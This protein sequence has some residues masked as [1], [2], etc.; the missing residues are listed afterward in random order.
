M[1]CFLAL[2]ALCGTAFPQA[3]QYNSIYRGE[4][5]DV[6][7]RRPNAFLV[8]MTGTRKPGR[9]LDVGMGQGR[10]SIFLAQQGWDVT[11]IDP[12]DEGVRLAK[13]EAARLG[14]KIHAEVITFEQFDFGENRWDLIVLT[15]EPTKAI[16]PKVERA[17]KPGGA[18][19]VEDRHLDTLRVWPGA[20]FADN[21]LVSLFPGLRVLRYEDV[22]ARPDWSAKKLDARL[23][24]LFAEKPLPRE[25]GCLWEGKVVPEGGT[26][27]FEVVKFLCK[28]AGWQVTREKCGQ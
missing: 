25:S 18:V 3:D 12:A 24:R 11:G 5:G 16:A 9:A 14:L 22:W 7:T 27:C 6:F 4:D 26:A 19:L 28:A 21:E 23:V 2:L 13:A 17:L 8:E 20:A 15:Y 10:N 1:R